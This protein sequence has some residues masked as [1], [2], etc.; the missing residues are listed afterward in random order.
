MRKSLKSIFILLFVSTFLFLGYQILSK[1]NYKKEVQQ[2]I[3]TIP[4]FSYQNIKGGI[5]TNENLKT[6]T[7]AIFV[8]FNTECEYCKEEA[9]MIHQNIKKFVSVQIIFISSEKNQQIKNFAQN[10]QLTNY[11]NVHFLCDSKVTFANT[12]DVNSIPSI[13]LYDKNHQLIEK[14]KG[15][16]K[17]EILIKKL[18]AE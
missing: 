3:K 6:E 8:Y 4:K 12:F 18:N 13:I 11:D 16:T 10:H 14:I 1:I 9:Q 2:N 7:P 17:P 5:F 15:Q